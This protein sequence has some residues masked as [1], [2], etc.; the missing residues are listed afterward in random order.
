MKNSGLIIDNFAGGGGASTGIEAALGRA[1]DIAINHDAEAV[2]MHKANHPATHHLCQSVWRADPQDVAGGRP[3]DLAW[4]SPDCKHF[5][6]AKGGKPV[7][8][9][10]RDLAWVVVHWA[11]RVRP[12]VIM[13]ENVE[14]CQ[15]WGPLILNAEGKTIPDPARRG[16]TFVLWMHALKKCGYKLEWRELRACDYGTPTIRKR[17]FMIAR[18]DG[19]PIAWPEKTHGDPKSEA[20]KEG[21]LLPWRTAAECIDWNIPCPSIFGRKRP[22][23]ENTLRR[24]AKGIQRYVIEAKQP[25]IVNLTHTGS[26]RVEPVTEPLRTTTCAHRGEKAIVT[27]YVARVAHGERDKSGKKRGQGQHAVDAP[28]PTVTASPE[29]AVI[30]PTLIQMGNGEREGQQP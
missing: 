22:L 26:D 21:R 1:V 30:A 12:R 9:N 19:V 16:E 13:R 14:E 24:I 4:F 5:S 2:A 8:K 3:I 15:D 25:F 20:V 18:C 27:P 17:F 7:E 29:F 6:K 23:A 10:I 28:L 11:R